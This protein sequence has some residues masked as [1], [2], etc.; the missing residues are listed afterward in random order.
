MGVMDVVEEGIKAVDKVVAKI[1]GAIMEIMG[2]V[3]EAKV[4][5]QISPK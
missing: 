5:F 1:G 2:K 4:G 3:V